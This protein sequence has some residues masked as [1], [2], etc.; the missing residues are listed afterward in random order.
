[1]HVEY[2]GM[3]DM[4][5]DFKRRIVGLQEK[6]D[7]LDLDLVVYGSCQNFQYLTGLLIDW[8]RWVDLGS[9]ANLVFVPRNGKPVLTVGEEWEKLARQSWIKDVRTFGEKESFE[10][11]IR[12]AVSDIDLRGKRIGVGDHVWGSTLLELRR[13]FKN[14]VFVGA[15]SLMDHVRMIKDS[16]EIER[17]RKVAELT[18]KAVHAVMPKI[19]KG[20]TQE[21]LRIE[22]EY[23]GRQLGASDVSFP[24][25]IGFVKSD[26]G[27]SSD[28]VTVPVDEGLKMGT[29]IAFDNGFVFDGYCSDFG[30]SF[31]YGSA[32]REFKMGY[33]SLQHAV[34]E[35]IDKMKEGSMRVCD[36]FP[37][38]EKSLDKSGFGDYLRARLPMKSV[39]H[40]IGV[41][42]HEPPWLDPSCEDLLRANMV[43]AIEPKLWN[44]GQYYFRVEDIVLVGK[45]KTEFLTKF[46]R[47]IFQL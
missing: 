31:H 10:G 25:W 5:F 18:D 23:E 8:R 9:K 7:E 2:E 36:V 45:K 17:L 24:P 19:K 11:L 29:S 38:I 40:N 3:N 12:N 35:T 28:L 21:E 1:V 39:G 4:V 15:E 30:R 44:A 33:E 37:L 34:V 42:V 47:D 6:M 32:R 13:V 14:P 16:G 46:D 43:M 41:E 27:I 22:L 20:V 26:S